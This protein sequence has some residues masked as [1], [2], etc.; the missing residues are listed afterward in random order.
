MAH[1]TVR[2]ELPA[3]VLQRLLA[4]GQLHT[5]DF[6]C[7][8]CHSKHCVWRLCLQNSA[9]ELKNHLPTPACPTTSLPG[10]TA[11]TPACDT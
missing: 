10:Q 5:Q 6:R 8:D 2:L 3:T 1:D 7:L 9:H 4:A 11:P